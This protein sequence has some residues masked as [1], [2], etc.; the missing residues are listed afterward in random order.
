M[1]KIVPIIYLA[2]VCLLPTP[3]LASVVEF[4]VAPEQQYNEIKPIWDILNLWSPSFLVNDNGDPVTWLK[5]T[6]PFVNRVILM[7]ATGGRPD[8]PGLEILKKDSLG[9]LVYDFANFDGYLKAALY[10]N[11]TPIIVLGAIPF[12]L[13]PDPYHIGVFGSITDPPTDYSQWYSFVKTLIAHCVETFGLPEVKTWQ[14]RLYT[15]PDNRDWWHGTKEEY[16]KLYDYTVA[17]ALEVIPDII[18]GPGNMLGEIEDHWGLEF[19]DHAFVGINY[20][21]GTTGSYMKFFT[22][23]AYERCEKDH[24]PLQQFEG[25]VHAIKEKLQQYGALDTIALGFDEGQLITDE[26]GVYLWLGDGTE[27]GDSWQAAYQIL[28]IREGLERIVQWGFTSDGVKTPKYN[29]IEMLEKMKGQ[30]RIEM[31]KVSDSRTTLAQA[32]QMIDGIASIAPDMSII[33]IF[34]YCH[35]KYRYRELTLTED[36]QS[37]QINIR[38]IPF[39]TSRVRIKHWVVD[40]SHSNYFNKWL[41]DSRDLPRVSYNGIGGSIFD[42]AVNSNFNQEGHVF[43]WYHKPEYLEIDDLEKLRPDTTLTSN[44]DGSLTFTIGMRSHQ[45]SLLQIIPDSITYVNE[46]P[47][48]A[49]H[50]AVSCQ[51]FPNPFNSSTT[52]HISPTNKPIRIFIYN[53]AGQLIRSFEKV[54]DEREQQIN[55][56][57]DGRNP[58]GNPVPS[59][60]YIVRVITENQSISRK[61][62]LLR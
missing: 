11:F 1:K 61:I 45:V 35:Y 39:A 55:L 2:T 44:D 15:E 46:Q 52:F 48:P 62:T 50:R 41:E 51:I 24:P 59:G 22:I 53:I 23:S 9:N 17:A 37:V 57:W 3:L 32:F 60:I 38:N 31:H 20:Y 21:T 25:R 10:N 12:V 40:S 16:F 49:Q 5:D 47:E 13:A 56:T 42:A 14:W 43:W 34:I 19:L 8:Y 6:H 28:G 26:D 18:I 36:P 58:A 4:D 33:N 30:R 54:A 27:Y 7:T 29:V